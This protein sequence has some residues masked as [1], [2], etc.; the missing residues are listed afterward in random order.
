[1]RVSGSSP[2]S[3][4]EPE[5]TRSKVSPKLSGTPVLT[6]VAAAMISVAC[7]DGS[8]SAQVTARPQ[9]Q[10]AP[11]TPQTLCP[12]QVIGNRRIPK[13]SVL[14]RLYSRPGEAYDS[15]IVERDFN[16]LWNTGYFDSVQIERVDDPTC[17]QL[18]VYVVEKPTIGSVEY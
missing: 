9:F 7:G 8:L 6:A 1:M 10:A 15:A 13:E 17:I 16:S 11:A 5:R 18:I 2:G 3:A 12:V 4:S 14:A